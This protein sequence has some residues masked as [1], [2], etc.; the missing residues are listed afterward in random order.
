M[1]EIKIVSKVCHFI[2]NQSLYYKNRKRNDYL[3]KY[4]I[5]GQNI[6][7]NVEI[8]NIQNVKIGSNTYMNSG[9]IHAG[10]NS[11]IIIG[12]WC[13]IGYNVHIKSFTHDSANPTGNDLIMSDKN[14][15]I[16]DNVWIGDNVYIKEGVS[17][18]NNVIIGANSVVTKNIQSN[19]V[20]GGVP[21]K[22]LYNKK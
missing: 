13:A 19:L 3:K 11:K 22:L 1:K 17:I 15:Y 21:A 14:I 12:D 5:N 7:A 2:T 16:G 20:F 6:T 18:G 10:P 4:G 8:F 9:Q